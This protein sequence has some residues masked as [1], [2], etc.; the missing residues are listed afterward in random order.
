FSSGSL[1]FSLADSFAGSL[2]VA[3]ADGGTAFEAVSAASRFTVATARAKPTVRIICSLIVFSLRPAVRKGNSKAAAFQTQQRLRKAR[4][5]A[6]SPGAGG[7]FALSGAWHTSC[8][9]KLAR[10]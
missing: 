9:A 1:L 10:G 7:V 6:L 2:L 5:L 4:N 3:V 8:F